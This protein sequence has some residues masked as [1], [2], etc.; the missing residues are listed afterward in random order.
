MWFVFRL[1]WRQSQGQNRREVLEQ[2]LPL[3]FGLFVCK[4]LMLFPSVFPP[5]ARTEGETQAI[6][7]L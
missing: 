4:R 7:G 5:R 3:L 6:T 1:G 2:L